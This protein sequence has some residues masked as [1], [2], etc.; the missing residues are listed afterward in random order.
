MACASDN[1]SA[2]PRDFRTTH[3]SVV[4]AA[5]R[6]DS[7]DRMAAL[8][9]LCQGYWYPLY[10]FVRRQGRDRQQAEDLTQDFFARLLEKNTLSSVQP[11]HGRFRSFL[12]ASLKNFLANDW[13]RAHAAKRGGN[14]SIISWDDQAVEDRY[15][16]EPSHNATP[17]KLFEQTWALTLIQTVLDRLKK[18][19]ADADKNQLFDAIHASLSDE[20]G[21]GTYSEI[22]AKLNMT[23]SAVKMSV[24]RM[25]RRFGDLLRTEIAQ[26]LPDARE[27]EEELRHLFTCL[28]N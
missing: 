17:E 16:R 26:T 2:G 25:R 22:A 11:E 12:L 24:L 20:G 9:A 10:A 23:E 3:W 7:P 8:T 27:V 18:E 21:A 15:L 6:P 19:Y 28:A 13:D 14:Y 5:K 1:D 4:L